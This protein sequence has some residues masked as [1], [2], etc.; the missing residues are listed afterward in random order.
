MNG[1]SK[2]I[3]AK[4]TNISDGNCGIT[5]LTTG[6]RETHTL[7][8]HSNEPV[9]QYNYAS[10]RSASVPRVR[11]DQRQTDRACGTPG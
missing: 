3:F 11:I 6:R 7:I 10:G 5:Q 2:G 1:K 8:R 4:A 9:W